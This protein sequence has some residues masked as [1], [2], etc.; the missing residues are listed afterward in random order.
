MSD[1]AITTIFGVIAAAI[2]GWLLGYLMGRYDGRSIGWLERYYAE[3]DA[4]TNRAQRFAQ[5][6][7]RHD[8]K[9][10]EKEG[11]SK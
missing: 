10:A 1:L 6:H 7:P 5:L 3:L 8:G 9:F 11:I 2:I 4:A